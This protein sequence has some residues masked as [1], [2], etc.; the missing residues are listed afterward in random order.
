MP[1][2]TLP[3][4]QLNSPHRLHQLALN[5]PLLDPSSIV[6]PDVSFDA[7][8]RQQAQIAD[9]SLNGSKCPIVAQDSANV[10]G[11]RLSQLTLSGEYI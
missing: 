11:L 9:G 2:D 5:R 4:A 6:S 3:P 1:I 10:V 8:G 7:L